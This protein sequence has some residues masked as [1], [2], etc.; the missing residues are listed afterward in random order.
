MEDSIYRLRYRDLLALCV[1]ALLGLGV[2]MVQSAAA[3][4]TGKLGWHWTQTGTRDV[5]YVAVAILTF[6][7]VGQFD[8]RL[9]VRDFSRR[10]GDPHT[11]HPAGSPSLFIAY[12]PAP[13]FSL[14]SSAVTL[15]DF[16]CS[17]VGWIYISG[18]ICCAIVLVPHIGREVNG[19]RRWIALGP[20]QL[21]ASEAGK[22]ACVVF[23]SWLLTFRPIDIRRF[24]GFLLCLIPLAVVC[25]LVVKEDFGTAAL[26]GLCVIA[27][28]LAGR[29]K[30]WHL[31]IIF[32]P[33]MAAGY[34]FIR[35]K[36]Y[37]WRRVIAFIDPFAAPQDEGYHLIQSL[38][39]FT[40]GGIMGKGL[41][42]G[43]QKLG[44]L[45]EDTT[46]FI[47]AIICEELGLF[48]AMLTVAL[49]LGLVWS[50]WQIIRQTRDTFGQIL[51][52]GVGAMIGMQAMMNIAVASVSVP[53]KG[54]ALPLVSF[55]G[56]G[57]VITCAAL[58]LVY[59][60]ARI[61]E[62]E[63]ASEPQLPLAAS[64]V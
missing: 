33:L 11:Q 36:D 46:D 22:W 31:A 58:G 48:G 18:V 64:A 37:R 20:I 19:A 40:S 63:Q 35:H 32:P 59:S 43:I 60:V 8:Y 61:A 6:L 45:P 56:S 28:M 14:L 2:I 41:G 10:R 44:Y 54:I 5:T 16:L 39:A 24:F 52:F 13:R 47:F 9:L 23:F 30:I 51:V 4:V 34:W 53:P 62:K 57:L 1:F 21:Q 55:G 25:L 50:C 17:P 42:N 38:L 3:G 27:M 12:A 29:A 15:R 7:V 26:I 49:Y